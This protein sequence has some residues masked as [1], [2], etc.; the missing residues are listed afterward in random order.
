MN[1]AAENTRRDLFDPPPPPPEP[2]DR[3]YLEGAV[4]VGEAGDGTCVYEH[5]G[6]VAVTRGDCFLSLF[7]PAEPLT[8]VPIYTAALIRLAHRALV[9]SATVSPL[10]PVHLGGGGLTVAR[11]L[12][13]LT[14]LPQHVVDIDTGLVEALLARYPL[15]GTVD[16]RSGDARVHA[17]WAREHPV[18][19]LDICTV[20]AGPEVVE[21]MEQVIAALLDPATGQHVPTILVSVLTSP[22]GTGA[23]DAVTAA[24]SQR[25]PGSEEPAHVARWLSP[26]AA[27]G[28]RGNMVLARGADAAVGRALVAAGTGLPDWEPVHTGIT[29]V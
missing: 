21:V 23:A 4:L 20:D 24:L 1:N 2:G 26:E 27:C 6:F 5:T 3:R 15:R 19:V 9:D 18:V 8:V 17:G 14:G 25:W 10:G 13:A 22:G 28:G 16:L 11:A 7:H 29:A 12:A